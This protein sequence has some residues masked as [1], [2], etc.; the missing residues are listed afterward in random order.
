MGMCLTTNSTAPEEPSHHSPSQLSDAAVSLVWSACHCVLQAL[1]DRLSAD[2]V[3][4]VEWIDIRG[5][6]VAVGSGEGG[7]FNQCSLDSRHPN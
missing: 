1:M 3:A 5:V 7:G 4:R 6:P 2:G